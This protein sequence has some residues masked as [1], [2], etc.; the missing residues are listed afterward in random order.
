[1]GAAVSRPTR[2]LTG[3][4]HG[5]TV[6]CHTRCPGFGR[7]APASGGCPEPAAVSRPAGPCRHCGEQVYRASVGDQLRTADGSGV[8]TGGF[9]HQLPKGGG[10][11]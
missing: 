6:D 9:Y 10:Q 3:H 7:P 4:N 8:C 2:T 11:R 5:R 1:M